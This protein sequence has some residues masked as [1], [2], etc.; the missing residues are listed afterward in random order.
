MQGILF[1]LL[2]ERVA[3]AWGEEYW[4]QLVRETPGLENPV[5]VGPKNY[6]DAA[7]FSLLDALCRER[8]IALNDLLRDF[9]RWAFPRLAASH[10]V[11]LRGHTRARDFLKTV[12]TV[13][14]T[15]VRMM[16][17]DA[18][19]PRIFVE[20]VDAST[21]VVVYDSRRRLCRLAEG[22]ILGVGDYFKESL[23]TSHE[24]CLLRGDAACRLRVTF[25]K[26]PK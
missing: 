3:E 7:L 26:P 4:T 11:F 21:V 16:Y 2:G 14:H 24:A 15:E 18:Y 13:V 12:E 5:F 22:L 19:L 9:G 25:Q 6:P 17:D 20:D 23:T 8:K 10:P 1:N